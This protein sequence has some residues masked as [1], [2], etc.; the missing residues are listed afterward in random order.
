MCL[1][2]WLATAGAGVA[3]DE[4][5]RA[6]NLGIGMV[7]VVGAEDAAEVLRL[8]R[9][10]GEEPAVIGA[11]RAKASPG[12]EDVVLSGLDAALLG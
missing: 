9:T 3:P 12:D 8:L 7:L 4:C 5:A 1:R 2:R 11:L 6:F 10:T